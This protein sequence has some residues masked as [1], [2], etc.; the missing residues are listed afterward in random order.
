M[1]ANIQLCIIHMY[2]WWYER[3]LVYVKTFNLILSRNTTISMPKYYNNHLII[4]F[5]IINN[6]YVGII[7][8]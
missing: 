2:V 5:K 3:A 1:W 4:S 6:A 8:Y 7:F